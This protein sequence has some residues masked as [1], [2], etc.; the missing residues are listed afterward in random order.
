LL[1]ASVVPSID[2]PA[3]DPVALRIST[4]QSFEVPIREEG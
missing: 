2:E 4:L 3:H 1:L